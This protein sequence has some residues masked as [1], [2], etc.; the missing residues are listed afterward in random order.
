MT[1]HDADLGPSIQVLIDRMIDGEMSPQQLRTCIER[2][3]SAPDG[4]RRCALAFLE[5]Q[6]WGEAFR[7]PCWHLVPPCLPA[8]ESV[9]P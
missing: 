2:L 5:A 6:S 9:P 3:D 1:N 4:W 7:S 8:A